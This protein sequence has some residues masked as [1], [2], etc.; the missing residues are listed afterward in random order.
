MLNAYCGY[1]E[2]GRIGYIFITDLHYAT[3]HPDN[4]EAL[5]RQLQAVAYIANNAQI[6]FVAI[7]GDVTDGEG[8]MITLLRSFTSALANIKK[9]LVIITGN[10]DDNSYESA[11][12]TNKGKYA[13][14]LL[15][16]NVSVIN[17]IF[18]SADKD[19][20]YYYFDLTKKGVRV[21]CLDFIDYP[22][23]KRGA[24][25]WGFSQTQVEWLCSQAFDT[26]LNIII[27]SHG[28]LV[29]KMYEWYNLG[30]QGGYT[31]DI[32]NAIVAFN[33][34]SSI[35]LYGN[36]YNFA[37]RQG[38]II[39]SH[40]GHEHFDKELSIGNMPCIITG[41]A[42]HSTPDSYGYVTNGYYQPVPGKE[43]T[44][45]IPDQAAATAVHANG[46]GYEF[47]YPS[48]RDYGTVNEA[49]FDVVSVNSDAVH[50]IR[51]GAGFD[52][53]INLV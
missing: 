27:F 22:S 40:H 15:V 9:P 51:F 16:D 19:D 48:D 4:N 5:I 52:R 26:N 42:K 45:I 53:D 32:K 11:A 3:S 44:Y 30:D 35:T 25:W 24:S 14:N 17:P 33:N 10:H 41:C 47:V 38:K 31:T 6:D 43:D 23:G 1:A 34:K 36:T 50:C 46:Y 28:Q 8:N 37:S 12:A 21:I 13:R 49:L 39:L 18:G 20:C 7:G 2:A 29:D